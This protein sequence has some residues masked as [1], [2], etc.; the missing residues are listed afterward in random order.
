ML[1]RQLLLST[2]TVAKWLGVAERT[3][4]LW[5]ECGEIPAVK[6]GKQWRFREQDVQTWFN[7]SA[8]VPF[9]SGTQTVGRAARDHAR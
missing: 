8:A 7:R 9:A 1:A 4:R 5:A 3:V 6:A 2:R